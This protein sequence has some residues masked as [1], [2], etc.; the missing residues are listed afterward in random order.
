MG[1]LGSLVGSAAGWAF[2][3]AWRGIA[4][5]ANG[6]PLFVIEFDPMLFLWAALG[7]TL[8]GTLAAVFPARTAAKL[9]PAVAIR[10]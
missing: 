3:M 8:V 7:A 4:K 2:L 10:G 1:C 9:D 6:T 5:N